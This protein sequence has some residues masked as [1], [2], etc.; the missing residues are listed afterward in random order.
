MAQT[1]QLSN[2]LAREIHSFATALI[3]KNYVMKWPGF[4]KSFV[5]RVLWN[6]LLI[7]ATD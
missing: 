1:S 4:R 5:N 7:Q 2:I 6:V 3:V